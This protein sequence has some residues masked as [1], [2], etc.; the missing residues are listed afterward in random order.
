M[1]AVTRRWTYHVPR[2]YISALYFNDRM[3]IIHLIVNIAD[4]TASEN[5]MNLPYL[6]NLHSNFFS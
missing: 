6:V 4:S 5:S 1:S 2:R 3:D